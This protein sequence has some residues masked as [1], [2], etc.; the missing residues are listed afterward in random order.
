MVAGM[1]TGNETAVLVTLW[2]D[3]LNFGT[4]QAP[5]VVKWDLS[6]LAP[7]ICMGLRLFSVCVYVYMCAR[8]CVCVRVCVNVCVSERETGCL[9]VHYTQVSWH[10]SKQRNVG[11]TSTTASSSGGPGFKSCLRNRLAWLQLCVV[12]FRGVFRH[13]SWV[14]LT[15]HPDH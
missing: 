3:K 2:F 12:D 11:M 7:R 14:Y 4:G 8:A 9:A 10:I 13:S 5:V 15:L 1:T 6:V